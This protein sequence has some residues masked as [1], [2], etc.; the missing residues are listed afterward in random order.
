[1]TLAAVASFSVGRASRSSTVTRKVSLILAKIG[2]RHP[3]RAS[4]VAVPWTRRDWPTTP[5]RRPPAPLLGQCA[6]ARSHHRKTCLGAKR[7]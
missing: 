1:M 5:D 3:K 7:V 2:A 4:Y 6:G